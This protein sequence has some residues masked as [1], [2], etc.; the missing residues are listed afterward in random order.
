MPFD[1]TGWLKYFCIAITTRLVDAVST[2]MLLKLVQTGK[3]GPSSLIT[4]GKPHMFYQSSSGST[5]QNPEKL[6]PND[7]SRFCIQ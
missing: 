1:V 3:I 7:W 4:H 2:P 6:T 5:G